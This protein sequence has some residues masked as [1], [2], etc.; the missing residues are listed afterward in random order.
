MLLHHGTI[1]AYI[2]YLRS[3]DTCS[4]SRKRYSLWA[5]LYCHRRSGIAIS[6]LFRLKSPGEKCGNELGSSTATDASIAIA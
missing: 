2:R 3:L 6:A 4:K 5:R 1:R